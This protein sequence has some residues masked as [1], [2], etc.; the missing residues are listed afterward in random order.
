MSNYDV[1]IVGSGIVG[2][3]AALALAKHSNLRIAVLESQA[4][5]PI[6][7][8]EIYSARV[9]AI[10]PAS[11]RIFQDLNVWET[12]AAKRISPYTHMSVCDAEGEGSIQFDCANL[13]EPA[14]GYI[15]EDQVIRESLQSAFSSYA[16]IDFI[17]P[18]K[19]V[20]LNRVD[21]SI[22]LLTEDQS[23]FTTKLLIAADG[24]NS[25]V[26]E[27]AGIV[28]DEKGYGHTAIV[29]TV[30][31]EL[32]HRATAW[33][34]FLPAGPL[35]FLPM[36]DQQ[37]CS[38]VWSTS[39]EQAKQLMGL[40]AVDFCRALKDASNQYLGKI[41]HCDTRHSFP[42]YQRHT[43]NYILSNLA[44]LGDAAHTLHPLAG[45]GVNL[46]LLDAAALTQVLTEAIKKQRNFSSLST[47]RR[48]ER[49]RKSENQMMLAGVGS[50]K[51]LFGN[52]N[53]SIKWLRNIGLDIINRTSV[54]KK[55]LASYASGYRLG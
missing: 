33:Q 3:T 22:Q 44:L 40:E 25:W 20:S 5:L 18:V 42:L 10:S 53:T 41:L 32:V 12:I 49:W 46:G 6:W 51:A 47:L 13:C 8:P 36:A 55:W 39:V 11:K 48:Y 52:E 7:R 27:Q 28:I 35:A 29:T 45:Q 31:T 2:A 43:K 9:S 21:D 24:A 26:R 34:R 1:I 16:Y 38:I 54:I 19:L 17:H 23:I 50:L 4:I 14:L 15:I 37:V 30:K